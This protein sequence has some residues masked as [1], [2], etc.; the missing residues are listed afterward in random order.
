[1]LALIIGVCKA[2]TVLTM[3][4][5]RKTTDKTVS[6]RLWDSSPLDPQRPQIKNFQHYEGIK[7]TVLH[8]GIN[9]RQQLGILYVLSSYIS[10]ILGK[11][12]GYRD[13]RISLEKFKSRKLWVWFAFSDFKEKLKTQNIHGGQRGSKKDLENETSM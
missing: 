6:V 3:K 1:M 9:E 12:I 8:L 4:H 11:I 13:R 10:S 2:L 7:F 5:C